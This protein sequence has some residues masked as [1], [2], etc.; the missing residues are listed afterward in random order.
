MGGLACQQLVFQ[1][2][3]EGF[4]PLTAQGR[5]TQIHLAEPTVEIDPLTIPMEVIPNDFDSSPISQ[6]KATEVRVATFRGPRRS[7]KLQTLL[8]APGNV[9]ES[10]VTSSESSTPEENPPTGQQ[11]PGEILYVTND[12]TGV[13]H[14][15][16]TAPAGADSSRSMEYD[17][18]RLQTA[19]RCRLK[20]P[21]GHAT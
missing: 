15:V 2:V 11:M 10:S 4:R 1:R 16:V 14:V 13:V 8:S 12:L 5:G 21:A 3:A 7:S 6:T 9:E 18:K 20:L 17:K 19:C